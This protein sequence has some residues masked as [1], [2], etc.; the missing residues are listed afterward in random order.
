M[1]SGSPP[2]VIKA[3][4]DEGKARGRGVKGRKGKEGSGIIKG[5]KIKVFSTVCLKGLEKIKEGKGKVM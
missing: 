4:E 1:A 5:R 3:R 2:C